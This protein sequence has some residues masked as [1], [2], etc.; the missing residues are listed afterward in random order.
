MTAPV[1]TG[2]FRFASYAP[3]ESL[4]VTRFEGYWDE[5]NVAR[6]SGITWRFIPDPT[7]RVLAL[8]A[9]DVDVVADVP[10]E[11]VATLGAKGYPIIR[12]QVGAY[13]ALSMQ[14]HGPGEFAIT[15]DL[16]MRKAIAMSIDREAIVDQVL[17]GNAERGRNLVPP[18]ILGEAQ[19]QVKGGPAST[20]RAPGS[21][22]TTPAG[23]PSV[24]ASGPRTV[25]VWSSSWSTASPRPT[26][27]G[28]SPR[29]SSR[30]WPRP[31]S[32]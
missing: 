5:P 25:S 28:P 30:S 11:S 10:R 6:T 27:T 8:E 32:R 19:D 3:K 9:G 15:G 2:P 23:R 24:T 12:S 13:E 20:W 16:T 17:E 4:S 29:S 18:A 1:G 26:S 31:G 7:A 14:I 21:C 22:S